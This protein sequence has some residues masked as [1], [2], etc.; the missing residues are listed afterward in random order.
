M[1]SRRT[2]KALI[3]DI[4]G[5]VIRD[6]GLKSGA[7]AAFPQIPPGTLWTALNAAMLPACRGELSRQACWLHLAMQLNVSLRPEDAAGLWNT[8]D[9]IRSIEVD[10]DVLGL[11]RALRG[12]YELG[13]VSNTMQE[14]AVALREMGI[15]D[16][17]DQVVLSHEVGLTKDAPEVFRLA[18]RKLQVLPSEAVF[19][20]D[21]QPYVEIATGIGLR[22]I[23]FTDARSLSH[24]L[25]SLGFTYAERAPQTDA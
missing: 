17:F 20:D 4:G 11:V 10:Q 21:Y 6:R 7:E 12:R 8:D 19:I 5:V 22:G 16:E 18:L 24:E 14:H 15:Y 13:V 2:P 1:S 25:K 3:F 9:F 23:V